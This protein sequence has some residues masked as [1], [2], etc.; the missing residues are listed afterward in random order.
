MLTNTVFAATASKKLGDEGE[1][2]ALA[3]LHSRGFSARLLPPNSKTYDIEASRNGVSFLVSVK[4]SRQKQH[5]RLGS[6]NSV[7]NLTDGNFVFAFL[8]PPGRELTAFEDNAYVLLILPA[9]MVRADSLRIHNAYWAQR[10]RESNAFSVMV[11]GYGGHH[12]D[13]WPRWLA[14]RDAWTQLP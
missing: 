3:L 8:P 4:A 12:R 9:S 1:S 11:K 14:F 7:S 13:M 2:H 5:V 10:R 6:R